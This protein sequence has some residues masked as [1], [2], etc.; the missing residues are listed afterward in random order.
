M[1]VVLIEGRLSSDPRQRGL[2][3]GSVLHS[4]EVS[5]SDGGATRSVPV[6]WVDPARPPR[7]VAGDRVVVVG[8]VRRRFFRAGGAVASRTEVE[9]GTVARA[10][11]ARARRA[12][13]GAL[14]DLAT[15]HA[16]P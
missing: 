11:S 9:A 8:S 12:V 10:G 7:L 16:A 6:V 14:S 2:P 15:D 4:Y 1:N 5:T 13:V 3:S